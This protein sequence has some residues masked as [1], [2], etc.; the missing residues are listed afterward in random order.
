MDRRSWLCFTGTVVACGGLGCR[1][2]PVTGRKQLIFIPEGNEI[3][4]GQQ[5]FS[6]V[7]SQQKDSAPSKFEPVVR[8]VGMRIAE[9]SGRTDYQWEIKV[10][11]SEEQNAF[12]LPGGKIV[13]YEG[14]LP[15]CQNEAGLAVVMSHEVAHVLARHGGERMRQQYGVD[16]TK[17]AMSSLRQLMMT[18][19]SQ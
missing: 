5:A 17:K 3:A 6:Q 7:T 13:V 12:C 8:E 15:V 9:A 16:M 1:S 19:K 18:L 14:I 11:Q 2:A 10:I 4:M